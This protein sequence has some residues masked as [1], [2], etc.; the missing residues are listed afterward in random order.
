MAL[1]SWAVSVQEERREASGWWLQEG[2]TQAWEVQ[3]QQGSEKLESSC[4]WA[5]S[6]PRIAL[7]GWCLRCGDGTKWGE[8]M[9]EEQEEKKVFAGGRGLRQRVW[10]Q[11]C[12]YVYILK[13]TF[14]LGKLLIWDLHASENN[15]AINSLEE[16]GRVCSPHFSFDG[17]TDT[18][19]RPRAKLKLGC[20][21]DWWRG[22]FLVSEVEYVD[23]RAEGDPQLEWSEA[24]A[25]SRVILEAP[26]IKMFMVLPLPYV[27]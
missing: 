21:L 5:G 20:G 22:K 18:Q 19:A 8:S 3:L 11:S 10:A 17:L 12:G 9:C 16:E 24:K 23:L 1:F 14:V 26:R 27:I 6:G 25:T 13:A 7:P 15:L 2:S 4:R